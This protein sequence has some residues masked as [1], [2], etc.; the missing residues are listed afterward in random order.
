MTKPFPNL[1]DE[2]GW[3]D[4]HC[5]DAD[6]NDF[7]QRDSEH[8]SVSRKR[9]TDAAVFFCKG[10]PI[11]RACEA[12]GPRSGGWGLWGGVLHRRNAHGQLVST[13]LLKPKRQRAG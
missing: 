1:K 4:R 2:P 11:R 7:H 13:D 10:C 3:V 8:W 9:L 6:P 5:Q 12:A